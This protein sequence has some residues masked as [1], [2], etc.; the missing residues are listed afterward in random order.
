MFNNNLLNFFVFPNLYLAEIIVLKKI[1]YDFE[2]NYAI[3]LEFTTFEK[4]KN[5]FIST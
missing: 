4:K 1:T 3:I 2:R 5:E